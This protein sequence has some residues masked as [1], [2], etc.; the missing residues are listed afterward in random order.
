MNIDM[1]EVFK[2]PAF[3]NLS[4]EQKIAFKGLIEQLNGKSVSESMPII[5]G[6]M[7]SLPKGKT[8]S[9]EEQEAMREAA[10]LSLPEADRVKFKSMLKFAGFDK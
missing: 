10:I 3:V 5:M 2:R 9:K 7:A 8:L 1:N 6:F 4:D